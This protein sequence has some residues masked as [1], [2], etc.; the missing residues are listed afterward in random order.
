MIFQVTVPYSQFGQLFSNASIKYGFYDIILPFMLVFAIVYGILTFGKDPKKWLLTSK[1]N[2]NITIALVI[3]L[4]FLYP[5]IMGIQPDPIGMLLTVIP[6]VGVLAVGIIMLMTVFGLVLGKGIGGFLK[7]L[8]IL[9]SLGFLIY[10]FIAGA[11]FTPFQWLGQYFPIFLDPQM[12]DLLIILLVFG[13][14]VWFVT[15]EEPSEEEKK[16][17]GTGSQRLGRFFRDL[18]EDEEKKSS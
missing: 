12:Q 4:I 9:F 8:L 16:K 6:N 13:I 2:V 17:K 10:S 1:K 18:I 7:Y 5:H 11:G 3:S 15:G 14:I